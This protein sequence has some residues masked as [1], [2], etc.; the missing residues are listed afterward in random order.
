MRTLRS[1][2][3][4]N[5][6]RRGGSCP[7]RKIHLIK[8]FAETLVILNIDN[9]YRKEEP[10]TSFRKAV[11]RIIMTAEPKFVPE[12]AVDTEFRQR[13]FKVRLIDVCVI[14]STASAP[15]KTTNRAW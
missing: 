1:A 14:W 10:E 11:G 2:R 12:D 9:V 8:R 3:T 13:H 4:A 15:L 6:Y 5:L 7:Y